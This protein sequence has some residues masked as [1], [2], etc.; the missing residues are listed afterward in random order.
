M[1]QKT[2][3]YEFTITCQ[4]EE[5]VSLVNQLLA[6]VKKFYPEADELLINLE[7]AIREMLANAVEHG[8]K[9]KKKATKF[10]QQP[11]I[12]VELYFKQAGI[13]IIVTDPG[14]GFNWRER[15]LVTMPV[16]TEKGRGLKIINKLADQ[17]TFNQQGN[18]IKVFFSL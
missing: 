8:C 2:K 4:A 12:K 14:S 13:Y 17:I 6:K 10:W 16:F 11:T 5:I 7:I 9:K 15:D 1:K 3:K 18:Q